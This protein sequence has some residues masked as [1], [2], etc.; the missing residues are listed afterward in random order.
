MDEFREWLVVGMLFMLGAGIA[1]TGADA[2]RLLGIVI[3]AAALI[4][5]VLNSRARKR[6]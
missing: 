2:G 6:Q 3:I 5:A 1:L 4:I